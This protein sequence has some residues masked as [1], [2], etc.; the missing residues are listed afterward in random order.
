MKSELQSANAIAIQRAPRSTPAPFIQR[1]RQTNV[2]THT[3]ICA[4]RISSTASAPGEFV[5]QVNGAK[6]NHAKGV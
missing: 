3:G 2:A 5:N 6:R 1:F 4:Q